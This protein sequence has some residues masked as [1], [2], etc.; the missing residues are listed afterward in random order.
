MRFGE[1][2]EE[3]EGISNKL[4]VRSGPFPSLPTRLC[5]HRRSSLE[6]MRSSMQ[7]MSRVVEMR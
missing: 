5:A 4:S 3:E 1:E 6:G 2:E 7:R